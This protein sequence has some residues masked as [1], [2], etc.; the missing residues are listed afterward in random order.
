METVWEVSLGLLYRGRPAVYT[1]PPCVVAMPGG[2]TLEDEAVDYD[3][4]YQHSAVP[5][6]DLFEL[7]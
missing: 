1:I 6:S 4:L 2:S 5:L 3:L 7:E